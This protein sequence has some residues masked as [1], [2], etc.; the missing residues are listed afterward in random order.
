MKIIKY[1]PIYKK[2]ILDYTVA[3]G[4]E[5]KAVELMLEIRGTICLIAFNRNK[6]FL[7]Y[8]I[9]A[10]SVNNAE[11]FFVLLWLSK[12]PSS[13]YRLAKRMFKEIKS[14][15]YKY[16]EYYRS[17]TNKEVRKEL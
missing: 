3:T 6:K 1:K 8:V 13:G 14:K 12:T 10:P 17:A 7:G 4:R 2:A 9:G 11:S 15:G 16:A 5:T